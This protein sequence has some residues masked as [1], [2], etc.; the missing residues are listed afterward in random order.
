[1]GCAHQQ[2]PGAHECQQGQ[3]CALGWQAVTDAA[4]PLSKQVMTKA[5]T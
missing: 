1:M 2:L 5:T 3:D 4:E